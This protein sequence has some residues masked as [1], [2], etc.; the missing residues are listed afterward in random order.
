MQAGPDRHDLVSA[1]LEEHFALFADVR[2]SQHLGLL[3]VDRPRIADWG[4]QPGISIT[5]PEGRDCHCIR[6][7]DIG[8]F[9]CLVT[10]VILPA[11]K[12]EVARAT[13]YMTIRHP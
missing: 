11:S 2:R 7:P 3:H 6:S 12:R 5:L 4:P 9:K 1:D 10:I 13:Y 8:I